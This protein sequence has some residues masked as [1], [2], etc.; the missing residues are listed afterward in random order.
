MTHRFNGAILDQAQEP[1]L[2]SRFTLFFSCPCWHPIPSQLLLLMARLQLPDWSPWG[3]GE[4]IKENERTQLYRGDKAEVR[5]RTELQAR[6]PQDHMRCSLLR[7]SF[8]NKWRPLLKLHCHQRFT[9]GDK[10]VS[11]PPSEKWLNRS[12]H[13][14]GNGMLH[15]CARSTMPCLFSVGSCLK[16]TFLLEYIA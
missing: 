11:F 16:M 7:S 5:W 12:L 3:W 13:I 10:K 4:N 6:P 14:C 1:I 15:L 8:E 9:P 2:P